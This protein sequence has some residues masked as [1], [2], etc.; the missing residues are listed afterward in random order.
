MARPP[1]NA[2]KDIGWEV[3]DVLDAGLL[4]RAWLDAPGERLSP[5]SFLRVSF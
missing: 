4:L 1:M 2:A 5:T 3:V